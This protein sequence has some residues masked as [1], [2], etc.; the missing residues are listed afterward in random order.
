MRRNTDDS[1]N[2][3]IE[4]VEADN[5][6]CHTPVVIRTCVSCGHRELWHPD[7]GQCEQCGCENFVFEDDVKPFEFYDV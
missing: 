7:D 1:D 5:S 2:G 4:S 6:R 3:A